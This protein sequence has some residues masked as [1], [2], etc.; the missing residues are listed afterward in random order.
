MLI[1]IRKSDGGTK[2][3]VK[4]VFDNIA[5]ECGAVTLQDQAK[6][7]FMCIK[8]AQGYVSEPHATTRSKLRTKILFPENSVPLRSMK[9]HQGP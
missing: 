9:A 5:K 7:N 1:R 8:E 3:D 2:Q 4:T 6:V